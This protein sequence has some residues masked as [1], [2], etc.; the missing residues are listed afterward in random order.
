MLLL[1]QIYAQNLS[2]SGVKDS[3]EYTTLLESAQFLPGSDAGAIV[4]IVH[5][6]AGTPASFAMKRSVA[7]ELRDQLDRLL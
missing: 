6:S 3:L 1:S 7:V 5:L 4:L 2:G